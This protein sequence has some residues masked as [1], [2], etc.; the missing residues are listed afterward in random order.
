MFLIILIPLKYLMHDKL[1]CVAGKLQ[2]NQLA[3][4]FPLLLY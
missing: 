2:I 1:D 3:K 4:Q